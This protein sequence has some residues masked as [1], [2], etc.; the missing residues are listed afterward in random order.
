MIYFKLIPLPQPSILQNNTL[1]SSSILPHPLS[2]C[3]IHFRKSDRRVVYS[4]RNHSRRWRAHAPSQENEERPP[5]DPQ[6]TSNQ[7]RHSPRNMSGTHQPSSVESTSQ[8]QTQRDGE[9]A[10]VENTRHN[11]SV[12]ESSFYHVLTEEGGTETRS[13][14]LSLANENAYAYADC[15]A[16]IDSFPRS[17]ACV[18][19]QA[20]TPRYTEDNDQVEHEMVNN[21]LYAIS[22]K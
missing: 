9:P 17:A 4:P 10:I 15:R 14:C 19:R 20:E 16:Y 18:Q 3:F 11:M 1:S 2:F 12:V 22:K 5:T 21:E 6:T 8:T 7:P 13:Q